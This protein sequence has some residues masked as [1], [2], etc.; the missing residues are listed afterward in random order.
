MLISPD[1][2]NK[3][4]GNKGW[5]YQDK[6]ISKKDLAKTAIHIEQNVIKENDIKYLK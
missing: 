1:E 4:L 2:I 6:K 3:S 5:E